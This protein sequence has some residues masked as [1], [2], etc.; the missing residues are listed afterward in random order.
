MPKQ[1][2]Q[3]P[4]IWL[5]PGSWPSV[6]KGLGTPCSPFLEGQLCDPEVHLFHHC[7]AHTNT[8]TTDLQ[9][10][11]GGCIQHH[12]V[13]QEGAK[14]WDHTL[15]SEIRVRHTYHRSE[16]SPSLY[17]PIPLPQRTN[18]ILLTHWASPFHP[19]GC[20]P[21]TLHDQPP[22]VT[23]PTP[24]ARPRGFLGIWL[25]RGLQLHL[26][27]VTEQGDMRVGRGEQGWLGTP[28]NRALPAGVAP[29]S[30]NSYP[31]QRKSGKG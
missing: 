9:L 19:S 29:G 20:F 1:Q 28:G 21:H 5:V 23:H 14:V 16:G 25:Q 4:A 24:G 10:I 17:F 8:H 3:N 31:P 18:L 7:N 26:L 11:L 27:V 2:N 6:L 13:L 15:R 12:E 22:L 30:G